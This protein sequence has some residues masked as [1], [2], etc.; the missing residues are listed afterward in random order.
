MEKQ[1]INRLNNQDISFVVDENG[2]THIKEDNGTADVA[3][4]NHK[5]SDTLLHCCL[6]IVE[7]VNKVA[8]V[9]SYDTNVFNIVII[10]Y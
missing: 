3:H 1:V 10:I 8:C 6:G 2:K 5:E 4:N 9:K 7:L